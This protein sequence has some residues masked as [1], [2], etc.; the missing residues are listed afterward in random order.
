MTSLPFWQANVPPAQRP[1]EC[2]P[3]L[4][5]ISAKDQRILATPDAA[6]HRLSWPEVQ[7]LIRTDRIDLFQRVPS[8]LRRYLAYTF[9]LRQQ[10]GSIMAFML[11]ERLHWTDLAPAD[12]TPFAH[13]S[14][15][16]ILRNDW[17]YGVDPRIAHLVVWTRFALAD[18]GAADDLTPAARARVDAFVDATFGR[19]LGPEKVVWFRN[20]RSL[21]SVHAVE[22]FHVMLFAPDEA[23]VRSVIGDGGTTGAHDAGR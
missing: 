14:D 1:T 17:P 5:D 8:D 19:R 2:P 16:R 11:R 4:L 9:A 12:P 22:H 23:F 6:F 15:V 3:F 10:H 13:P 7:A 20:W 18:D 21:K